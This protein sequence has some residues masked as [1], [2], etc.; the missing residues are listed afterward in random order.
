[1]DCSPTTQITKAAF[2]EVKF[3]NLVE[4]QFAV[5]DSVNRLLAWETTFGSLDYVGKK[6]N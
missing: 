3:G 6:Q 1:M 2:S 4:S 5:D